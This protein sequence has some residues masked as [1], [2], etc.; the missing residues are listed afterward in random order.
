MFQSKKNPDHQMK[1]IDYAIRYAKLNWPVLPVHYPIKKNGEFICSCKKNNCSSIG[2]HPITKHGVKDATTDIKQ[3]KEWFDKYPK[4]NIGIATGKVSGLVCVDIDITPGGFYSLE[5]LEEQ[6]KL[7]ENTL[8]QQT[9]G[10]G[11]HLFFKYPD[12]INRIK[13]KTDLYKGIDIRGDQGYAIAAPSL[14]KSGNYYVW[15]EDL[16]DDNPMI[17]DLPDFLLEKIL[18]SN[19]NK[20]ENRIVNNDKIQEG[21]RNQML[22]SLAGTM[23]NKGMAEASIFAALKIEN[24]SKCDPPLPNDEI[25]KIAN[26]ISKYNPSLKALTNNKDSKTDLNPP[27]L[28]EIDLNVFD[29]ILKD[30]L[31]CIMPHTE[32]H[33]M[34]I[35]F[36]FLGAFGNI[37]DR[38]VHFRAESDDHYGNIFFCLVGDTSKGRKGSSWGYVKRFFSKID[39]EWSNNRVVNGLSSGE[40]LIHEVRDLN[41][42]GEEIEEDKGV[43]DK[44]LL[45]VQ[46]EFGA[47]LKQ[48]SRSNNILSMVIRD[49]WDTGKLRTLVKH[50]PSK[51]TNAHISIIGHITKFELNKLISDNDTANGF[52][53][54]FLWVF[55]ER[56]KKLPFGGNLD[57]DVFSKLTNRVKKCIEIAKKRS[58]SNK[59]IRL[60]NSAKKRWE[61]VYDELSEGYPGL[62]GFVTSRGESQVLRL[63]MLFAILDKSEMIMETHLKKALYLWQYN[64]KSCIYIFGNSIGDEISDT[65]LSNLKKTHDGLTKTEIHSLFGNHKKKFEIDGAISQLMQLEKITKET[66]E[67]GGRPTNRYFSII[68]K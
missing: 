27:S 13:N 60:D 51:A 55:V 20:P 61:N 26:S 38:S 25:Q 35:I 14:H 36:N 56:S 53:N 21:S 45:I 8:I 58:L 65:I 40:G 4:A 1:N 31:D 3:I 24:Q 33:P 15:E 46:S 62:I 63:A 54:R 59:P 22:T 47:V 6:Y 57:W 48:I 7:S 41:E 68:A 18:E 5:L 28:S 17:K 42:N 66:S 12:Q 32:A 29:G 30:L 2:K 23:R 67:T 9:G 50:S 52:A 49:S 37:I 44:R 39:E 64:L 16:F 43:Q 19:P 34:A 10:N 11:K